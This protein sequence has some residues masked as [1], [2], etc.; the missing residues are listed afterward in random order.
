MMSTSSDTMKDQKEKILDNP[1]FVYFMIDATHKLYDLSMEDQGKCFMAV[2]YENL[3][4]KRQICPNPNQRTI[5]SN[6]DQLVK[7]GIWQVKLLPIPEKIYFDP[8]NWR[9]QYAM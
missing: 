4:T 9:D 6:L 5:C 8:V 7:E 2:C 1:K 3:K